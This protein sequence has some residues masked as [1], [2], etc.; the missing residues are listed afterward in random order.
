MLTLCLGVRRCFPSK[1]GSLKT[2][3]CFHLISFPQ[4]QL[5]PRRAGSLPAVTAKQRPAQAWDPALLGACP[6][7]VHVHSLPLRGVPVL[8][9]DSRKSKADPQFIL[10]EG[11]GEISGSLS[12]GPTSNSSSHSGGRG[13]CARGAGRHGLHQ[14]RDRRLLPSGQDDVSNRHR[15]W[16][17]GSRRE[18]GGYSA[19]RG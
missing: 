19:V 13:S 12:M 2:T 8:P 15:Q 18:P 3:A 4:G 9:R 14:R 6:R 1:G 11:V 5:K 10:Q 7:C 17:R 16:G